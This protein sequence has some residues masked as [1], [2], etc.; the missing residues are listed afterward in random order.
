[1]HNP[2]LKCLHNTVIQKD[3]EFTIVL[4]GIFNKCVFKKMT[5]S[6]HFTAGVNAQG[7]EATTMMTPSQVPEA[8]VRGDMVPQS[9]DHGK[10]H[11]FVEHHG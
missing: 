1:M 5:C 9:P 3:K 4:K 6:P 11:H 2:V 7:E 8:N 10:N